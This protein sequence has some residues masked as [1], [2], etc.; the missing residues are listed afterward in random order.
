M[1]LITRFPSAVLSALFLAC[2]GSALHAADVAPKGYNTPIPVDVLTPDTVKTRLGT[3]KYFDGFPD[4]ETMRKARRQ[5]DLGR[6]ADVPQFH[7]RRFPGD[8]V[9]GPS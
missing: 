7:A 6:G 4:D 5:V 1:S 8:A 2:S 3:F 9:C